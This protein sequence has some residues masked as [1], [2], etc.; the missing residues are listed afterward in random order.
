MISC[1]MF[2]SVEHRVIISSSGTSQYL[3]RNSAALRSQPL[4]LHYKCQNA[5]AIGEYHDSQSSHRISVP[6][7]RSVMWN[8]CY[9]IL[10]R[11]EIIS[12]SCSESRKALHGILHH[13]NMWSKQLAYVSMWIWLMFCCLLSV[14]SL[15][16]LV[17]L[18]YVGFINDEISRLL[19]LLV[20]LQFFS[21]HF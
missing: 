15:G 1:S 16:V 3:R 19:H 8:V 17:H 9:M 21:Y 4:M 12:S 10:N 18:T 6:H 20:K 14:I 13:F 5:I 2:G 7:Y 11:I